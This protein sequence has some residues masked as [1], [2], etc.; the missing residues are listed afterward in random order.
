M[1][2]AEKHKGTFVAPIGI[3]LSLFIAHLAGIYYTGAS[4]NPARSFGPCVANHSFP[5]EHWIYW[6]GP[7][8][9]S[10][11]ATGFFWL[12]KFCDYETA[13]PGQDF[14]DLE[15]SVF[16]PEVHRMRPVIAP[17]TVLDRSLCKGLLENTSTH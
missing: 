3:G 4:L 10:L 7:L 17:N 2:A 9:G 15:A 6:V 11:L 5:S 12:I 8:L 1:L 13:N 14:D 16:N